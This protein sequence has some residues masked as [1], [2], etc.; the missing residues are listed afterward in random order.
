MITALERAADELAVSEH[1]SGSGGFGHID[2]DERDSVVLEG[3]DLASVPVLAGDLR[4]C[5]RSRHS[6]SEGDARASRSCV[7]CMRVTV[8]KSRAET[9]VTTIT[10]T[11]RSGLSDEGGAQQVIRARH[12]ARRTRPVGE[13]RLE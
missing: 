2:I 8:V 11:F 10:R 3:P 12:S 9:G 6:A 7:F 1:G 13:R 5:R 4:V